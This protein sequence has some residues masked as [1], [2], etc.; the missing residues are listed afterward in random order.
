MHFL[1]LNSRVAVVT[2]GAQ[3]IGVAIAT[4]LVAAGAIVAIADI[5]LSGAR[6]FISGLTENNA[7]AAFACDVSDANSVQEM[8]EAVL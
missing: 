3:G 5:N 6:E 7:A 1:D 8:I 4:R 2:G